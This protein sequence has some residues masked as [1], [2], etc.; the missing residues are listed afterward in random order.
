MK[1]RIEVLFL[2]VLALTGCA[3]APPSDRSPLL[4]MVYN[5]DRA[6][7]G[8]VSVRLLRDGKPLGMALTDI[9]GRFSLP[10]VPFGPITLEFTKDTYE[11]TVWTFRFLGPSQVIYMKMENG[12]QLLEEAGGSI[13]KR[14]W[15]AA[16][17]FLDRVDK[18]VPHSRETQYLRAVILSDQGRP[19]D[20]AALLETLSSG[21]ASYSVELALA[22]LYQYK[23]G[24]SAKALAH[25]KRALTFKGDVDVEKRVAD[26][27]TAGS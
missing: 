18:L 7:V 25:L 17:G 1:W 26:L 5:M 14:D 24:D 11:P 19:S 16:S 20:A 15:T 21:A 4:G 13:E 27:Q 22:D 10:D 23:L 3:S 9:R 2:A 12:D 6:P 8:D